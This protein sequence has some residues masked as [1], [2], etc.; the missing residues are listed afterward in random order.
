MDVMIFNSLTRQ[1][2]PGRFESFEDFIQ[3]VR[4]MGGLVKVETPLDET[5][6]PKITIQ[7]EWGIV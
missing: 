4:S 5:N 7:W 6:L 2:V 1:S 3:W